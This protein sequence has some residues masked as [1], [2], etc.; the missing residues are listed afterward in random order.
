VES[1][2]SVGHGGCSG[3]AVWVWDRYGKDSKN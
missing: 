2:E 1:S 3:V